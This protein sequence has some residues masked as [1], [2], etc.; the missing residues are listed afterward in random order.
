MLQVAQHEQRKVRDVF[1]FV[2]AASQWGS[3]VMETVTKSL[4][5]GCCFRS[6]TAVQTLQCSHELLRVTSCYSESVLL[7][8]LRGLRNVDITLKGSHD[9]SSEGLCDVFCVPPLH[10]PLSPQLCTNEL[11]LHIKEINNSIFSWIWSGSKEIPRWLS[12]R[13]EQKTSEIPSVSGTFIGMQAVFPWCSAVIVCGEQSSGDYRNGASSFWQTSGLCVPGATPLLPTPNSSESLFVNV[14]LCFPEFRLSQHPECYNG[15]GFS[16]Q[17]RLTL[18]FDKWKQM[19]EQLESGRLCLVCF[20]TDIINTLAAFRASWNTRLSSPWCGIWVSSFWIVHDST[21]HPAEAW[22]LTHS[23]SAPANL[24]P[25]REEKYS[26]VC[27][28]FPSCIH[29]E[30]FKAFFC[31]AMNIRLTLS[32]LFVHGWCQGNWPGAL[33]RGPTGLKWDPGLGVAALQNTPL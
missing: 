13:C 7:F 33:C 11:I 8:L 25:P 21:L 22:M 15:P 3:P 16:F 19:W 27:I 28:C 4:V 31:F 23:L 24:W 29:L 10:F 12:V 14:C 18:Q 20:Y 5:E 30:G 6:V 2:S 32:H 9:L 17:P 1:S 26:R